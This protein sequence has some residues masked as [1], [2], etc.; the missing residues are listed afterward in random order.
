M[1]R[2][3]RSFVVVFALL[4]GALLASAC[5]GDN[6]TPGITSSIVAPTPTEPVN[7]SSWI[8]V[9]STSVGEGARLQRGEVISAEV[10]WHITKTEFDSARAAGRFII[11]KLCT[12]VD[13]DTLVV[14]CSGNAI[15]TQDGTASFFGKGSTLPEG[16]PYTM[17][18]RTEY[19]H[20]VL[21]SNTVI[22]PDGDYGLRWVRFP[23]SELLP[24]AIRQV[25]YK[26]APIDWVSPN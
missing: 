17:V 22:F 20:V 18:S 24:A 25:A 14:S 5:A 1:T 19:V 4:S 2:S 10:Q 26:K 13:Q 15:P 21:T 11:V 16:W 12:G 23:I 8:K 9:L 3:V 6:R 7:D